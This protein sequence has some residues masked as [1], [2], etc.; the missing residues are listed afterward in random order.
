MEQEEI[1]NIQMKIPKRMNNLKNKP[2]QFS[3]FQK[4]QKKRTM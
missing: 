1:Q 3:S 4:N 2:L